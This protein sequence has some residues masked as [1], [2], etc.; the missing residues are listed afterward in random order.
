MWFLARPLIEGWMVE[1]L[2]PEARI[3]DTVSGL[4]DA[5]DRLPRMLDGIEESA[6]MLAGG[7]LRLHPE[8]IAALKRENGPGRGLRTLWLIVLALF[9]VLVFIR[10]T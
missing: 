10:L 6:S 5:V 1:N 2:G 7:R 3:R 4:A 8:T 9:A